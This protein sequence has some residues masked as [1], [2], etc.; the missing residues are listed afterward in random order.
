MGQD[1]ERKGHRGNERIG[2]NESEGRS[3][4]AGLVPMGW[5][6]LDEG[7]SD[8]LGVPGGVEN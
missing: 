5:V 1:G 4:K 7:P 8:S 3:A 6:A 2:H